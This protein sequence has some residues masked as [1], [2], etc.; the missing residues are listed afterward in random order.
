MTDNYD[1]IRKLTNATIRKMYKEMN[2]YLEYILKLP[3][4]INR[5]M[6]YY[7][8]GF[9]SN[10]STLERYIMFCGIIVRK[11]VIEFPKYGEFESIIRGAE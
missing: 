2:D 11:Y 3:S 5:I 6:R 7:A 1:I 9:P 4:T 8:I 10:P